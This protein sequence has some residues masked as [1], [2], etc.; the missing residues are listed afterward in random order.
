MKPHEFKEQIARL[1][2]QF[3]TQTFSADRVKLIWERIESLETYWFKR[4]VDQMILSNNP[5]F[6]LDE[7][8][9]NKRHSEASKQL[10]RDTI[11]AADNLTKQTSDKSFSDFLKNI[12]ANSAWDAVQKTRKS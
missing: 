5:K 9:R 8:I 2:S 3:G 6:D 1:V 12:G 4:I 7:A 11:A 10:A